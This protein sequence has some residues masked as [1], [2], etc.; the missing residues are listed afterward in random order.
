MYV[1]N[2]ASIERFKTYHRGSG[3]VIEN[4]IV[5]TD[6]SGKE[7]FVVLDVVSDVSNRAATISV[8]PL[9]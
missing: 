8:D 7:D 3:F 5:G 1:K 2:R 6:I 9:C 4:N